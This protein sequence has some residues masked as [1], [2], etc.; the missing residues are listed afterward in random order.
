MKNANK[1]EEYFNI[2][3]EKEEQ[4][5]YQ[6][7]LLYY[8]KSVEEDPNNIEAYFCMNLI[9]SYLEFDSNQISQKRTNLLSI[10]NDFDLL[11]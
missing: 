6:E 4:G 7:A 11:D 5:L 2:A 1:S 9:N 3:K 8:T 10:F